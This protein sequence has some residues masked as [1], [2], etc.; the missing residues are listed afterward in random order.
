MSILVTDRGFLP[1]DWAGT[2]LPPEA[3]ATAEG[4]GP[5]GLALG[6][7]DD[8]RPLAPLLGRVA[9]LRVAFP[10]FADGRGFTLARRLR[11]MGYAGRLRAA[12]PL[13]ADQYA[14]AR[15]AGFDEVEIPEE[16]ARRQPWPHW[17]ARAAGWRRHDYRSRL[18]AP[19]GALQPPALGPNQEASLP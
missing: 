12:G 13:I 2:L 19:A 11:R 8:P 10:G 17:A 5:F 7:A 16:I 3:L 1:D 9:L 6:P 15:R 18:T 14:L 4:P